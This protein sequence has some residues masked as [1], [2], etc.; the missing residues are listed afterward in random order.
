MSCSY[1]KV[2]LDS[3]SFSNLCFSASKLFLGSSGSS[4]LMGI[5]MQYVKNGTF[6]SSEV[7]KKASYVSR[8]CQAQINLVITCPGT[9]TNLRTGVGGSDSLIEN[10]INIF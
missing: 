4:L 1:N 3:V 8:I 6:L 2:V 10:S 9:N 5:H 7:L